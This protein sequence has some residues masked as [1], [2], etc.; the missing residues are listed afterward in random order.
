MK[1][2]TLTFRYYGVISPEGRARQE[3]KNKAS[4]AA[5]RQMLSGRRA[6]SSAN[7]ATAGMA[8]GARA[9]SGPEKLVPGMPPRCRHPL[10]GALKGHIRLVA[11][12]DLTEPADPEWGNRVWGDDTK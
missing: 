1:R 9:Y 4:H 5:L 11:G 6:A 7:P 8:D 3:E 12:T 10:Y 2:Q